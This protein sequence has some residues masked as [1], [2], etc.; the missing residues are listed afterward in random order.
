[1]R[2][3]SL[4]KI[5][6]VNISDPSPYHSPMPSSIWVV[7]LTYYFCFRAMARG[8]GVSRWWR[9][10]V[11]E[12]MKLQPGKMLW[13]PSIMLSV[14]QVSYTCTVCNNLSTP[15]C[16]IYFGSSNICCPTHCPT[17]ASS[18]MRYIMKKCYRALSAANASASAGRNSHAIIPSSCFRTTGN[19]ATFLACRSLVDWKPTLYSLHRQ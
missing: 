11:Q 5:C 19:L 4:P 10:R 6:E 14:K 3:P 2:L 15:A 9:G 16:F 7:T 1:M 17:S 8:H 13:T 12:K 18:R